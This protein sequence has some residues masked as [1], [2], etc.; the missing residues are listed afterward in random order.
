MPASSAANASA[1]PWGAASCPCLLWSCD[2]AVPPW[3]GVAGVNWC[4]IDECSPPLAVRGHA[5]GHP[6]TAGEL[7]GVVRIGEARDL[8]D[9]AGVRRL[10]EL[11]VAE[12]DALV[13]DVAGRVL[14]EDESP[15]CSE[16]R[17]TGWP[18]LEL[19]CGDA[20]ERAR[21]TGRTA[22]CARPEQSKPGRR[23]RRRRSGTG[24]RGTARPP[25]SPCC[26]VALGARRDGARERVA[27]R[28]GRLGAAAVAGRPAAS[29]RSPALGTRWRSRARAARRPASRRTA[30]CPP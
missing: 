20:R 23:A 1:T 21:R 9:V 5:S 11:V 17:S 8:H 16:A 24:C 30:G 25:R 7:G 2:A 3:T 4:G 29:G 15:G 18:T 10:E 27:A 14:E 13:V 12:V 6:A 28:G 19:V 22:Y 26:A